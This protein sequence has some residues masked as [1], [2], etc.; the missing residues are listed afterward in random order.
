MK[1]NKIIFITRNE[2]KYLAAKKY[3]EKAGFDLIRQKLE[4]PEIQNMDVSEVVKFSVKFMSE[5]LKKPVIKSDQGLYIQALNGF[6]GAYMNDVE[7][8]IGKEGFKRIMQGIK[9][10]RAKFVEAL[11]F[12]NPGENAVVFTAEKKGRLSMDFQGV[13]GFGIDFLF[14]LKGED[15]TIASFPQEKVAE[16]YDFKLWPKMIAFLK[17]R[18][19]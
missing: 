12:C 8:T 14:I 1:N 7:K 18:K 10:R 4:C 13:N 6:P 3:F 5:K 9:N 15:K 19:S 2:K 16:V 17:S 11:A